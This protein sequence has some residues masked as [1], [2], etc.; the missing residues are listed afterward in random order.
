MFSNAG[1]LIQNDEIDANIENL[2]VPLQVNACGFYR[3]IRKTSMSVL[4]PNGR[5]DYQLLYVASGKA[6]F[7]F[8]STPLEAPV[9]SMVIYPPEYKQQYI[10]YQKD[11]SEVYWI[12]F[13][14]AEVQKLL[15][16]Y[17]LPLHQI[18]QIGISI[19]IQ[20][21]FQTIIRELQVTRIYRDDFLALKLR[22]LFLLISR[23]LSRKVSDTG[24]QQAIMEEAVRYFNENYYRNIEIQTYASQL[25]M[26]TCWFIRSFRQ[27]MGM[28][29][30]KYLTTIRTNRAKELLEG[31]AYTISEV[32]SIVGYDNPLY[33]SRIFRNETGMSPK[34]YRKMR[35][36]A[37]DNKSIPLT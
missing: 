22:E 28:P 5:Y 6:W 15:D 11:H 23:S 10:Y 21:L 25:H 26:S 16:A 20:E 13:T 1:Y 32:G 34:Q 29:P 12:H 2:E 9:G 8:D 35:S 14:G 24:Q 27:Y 4:R 37:L 3:L 33:F 19:Q 30:L 17:K 36:L 18:L 7:T 31:T